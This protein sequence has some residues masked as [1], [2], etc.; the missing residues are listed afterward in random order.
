[1]ISAFRAPSISQRA[2]LTTC[3]GL[4]ILSHTLQ[5][6]VDFRF[7]HLG[8]A[9]PDLERSLGDYRELFGYTLSSGPFDDPIQKVRVCFISRGNEPQIELI[10]P[11]T[12]DAPIRQLLAKGGG[13]YHVCYEVDEMEAAITFL[14]GNK[15][16]LI[17]G[18]V[19]AVAFAGRRIAWFYTPA[20]Q[21]VEIV[22]SPPR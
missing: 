11:L 2:S 1:M 8:V 16:M 19:P 17:S 4:L 14:R 7:A 13:A 18:P 9:V 15:C 6:T 10:A 12:D 5:H 3:L 20:R 21:L 22:E